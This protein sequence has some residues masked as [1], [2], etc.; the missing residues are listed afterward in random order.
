MCGLTALP[1]EANVASTPFASPAPIP[2][3][4]TP[5]PTAPAIPPPSTAPWRNKAPAPDTP[6]FFKAAS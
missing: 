3:P 5:P 6:K 2:A 1:A 4:T